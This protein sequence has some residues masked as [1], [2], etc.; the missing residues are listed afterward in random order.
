M[1]KNHRCCGCELPTTDFITIA[2]HRL[3]YHAECH[4][5]ARRELRAV[6]DRISDALAERIVQR[7]TCDGALPR[8]DEL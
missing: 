7:C 3:P 1:I 4:A 8:A 2:G 5:A 6:R